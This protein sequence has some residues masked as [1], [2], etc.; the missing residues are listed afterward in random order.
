[1]YNVYGGTSLSVELVYLTL[2][3]FRNDV[4]V[5]HYGPYSQISIGNN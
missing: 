1:M 4:I 2:R 5:L 3:S